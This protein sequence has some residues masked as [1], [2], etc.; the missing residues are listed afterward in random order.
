MGTVEGNTV[1]RPVQSW[2]TDR[3]FCFS[4][5][6]AKLM[7]SAVVISPYDSECVVLAK[8]MEVAKEISPDDKKRGVLRLGAGRR[9]G[10]LVDGLGG[11]CY[12]MA[13]GCWAA[14]GRSAAGLISAACLSGGRRCKEEGPRRRGWRC[15]RWRPWLR[16]DG[17]LWMAGAGNDSAAI[18]GGN[19]AV[20]NQPLTTFHVVAMVLGLTVFFL[21]SYCRF[22]RRLGRFRFPGAW[23]V[24]GGLVVVWDELS[25]GTIKGGG[26]GKRV[27]VFLRWGK[28]YSP[29]SSTPL[30]DLGVAENRATPFAN[31]RLKM[32][33]KP[34]TAFER[35]QKIF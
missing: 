23:V 30:S 10:L 31:R 19:S 25:T 29:T 2:R 20:F 33:R 1:K 17:L 22:W 8:V 13:G 35:W 12:R 15:C 11:G 34:A 26:S 24:V 7:V 4:L 14:G 28:I 9:C 21:C 6:L 5:A 16:G 27:G 3:A 18:C 32:I